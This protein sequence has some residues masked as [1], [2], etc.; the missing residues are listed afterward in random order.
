MA[1]VSNGCLSAKVLKGLLFVFTAL[2][3]LT[4]PV[5]LSPTFAPT[6]ALLDPR[7]G[8]ASER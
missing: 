4:P 7:S 6:H 1:L 3:G 8:F 5:P 2:L